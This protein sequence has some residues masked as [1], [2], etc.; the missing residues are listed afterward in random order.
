[1][2]PT[3]TSPPASLTAR[4]RLTATLAHGPAFT[5]GTFAC[6]PPWL[7]GRLRSRP[8]VVAAQDGGDPVEAGAVQDRALAADAVLVDLQHPVQADPARTGAPVPV[9]RAQSHP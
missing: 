2:T 9:A 8:A 7:T 4:L 5:T 6:G 1:M 3:L